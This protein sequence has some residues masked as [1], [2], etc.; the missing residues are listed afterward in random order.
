MPHFQ[1]SQLKDRM[2]GLRGDRDEGVQN[3][4]PLV[5]PR[6]RH[7]QARL[8]NDAVPIEQKVN[9]QGSWRVAHESLPIAG[10]LDRQNRVQQLLRLEGS[11]DSDARIPK[12]PASRAVHGL[13][14]EKG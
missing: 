1:H 14:L 6:M 3:E 12:N 11:L 5:H 10:A 4:G 8:L 9:V 7:R 13:C 2:N